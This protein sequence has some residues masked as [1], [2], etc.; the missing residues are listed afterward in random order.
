[1]IEEEL[2]VT[3][4]H[5]NFILFIA[6]DF[7][8]VINHQIHELIKPTESPNNHAVGIQLDCKGKKTALLNIENILRLIPK[9]GYL[10]YK[11]Q[12]NMLRQ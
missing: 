8:S 2:T 6:I 3:H 11:G 9:Q 12:I 1:M 10:E 4:H 7:H 5:A